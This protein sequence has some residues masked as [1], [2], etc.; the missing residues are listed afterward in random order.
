MHAELIDAS[1]C[2]STI[3]AMSPAANCR[4]SL[5]G[6]VVPPCAA[7]KPKPWICVAKGCSDAAGNPEKTSGVSIGSSADPDGSPLL[8][9]CAGNAKFSVVADAP[10]ADDNGSITS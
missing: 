1:P 6:A 5:R 8:A 10:E 4:S 9:T 2:T 7:T 3:P